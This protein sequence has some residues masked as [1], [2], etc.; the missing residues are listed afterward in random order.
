VS[1]SAPLSL[2][3]TGLGWGLVGGVLTSAATL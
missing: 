2:T 1:E 3:A